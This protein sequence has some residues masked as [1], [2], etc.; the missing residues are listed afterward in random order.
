[1]TVGGRAPCVGELVLLVDVSGKHTRSGSHFDG[2]LVG[3]DVK[4]EDIK[5]RGEEETN[6][7]TSF[8]KII[9]KRN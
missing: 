3:G 4:A 6:N 1:M 8:E 9:L 2:G 5:S 7:K